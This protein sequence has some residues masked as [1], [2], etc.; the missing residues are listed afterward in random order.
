MQDAAPANDD[1][2][3]TP[4]QAAVVMGVCAKTLNVHRKAGR[5]EAANIS[6]GNQKPRWRYRRSDVLA[7]MLRQTIR[8]MPAPWQ[9]T[10]AKARR[11]T[12]MNSGT[13]ESAIAALRA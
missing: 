13:V 9:S 7:F 10:N 3:L 8:E 2:Y 1:P 12:G 11:T 6:T 5:I 4:R